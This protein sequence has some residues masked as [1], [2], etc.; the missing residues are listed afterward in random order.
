M[1]TGEH[2]CQKGMVINMDLTVIIP[3]YNVQ[4]YIAAC[5]RSVMHFPAKTEN[6]Q[7]IEIECLVIND[8]SSDKTAEI[9]TRY[10]QRDKRIRLISQD[11]AG[12]SAARNRGLQEAC[13][14]YIMFLDADDQLCEDAFECIT[15]AIRDEYAEF[16][17]F[18]YIT[19]YE[20]GKCVSQELPIQGNVSLDRKEGNRLMYADSVFNTCW[21]KMFLNEIIRQKN[22]TFRVDLP[23]GED[24][25]FVLEYYS[26][27][28]TVYMT[29]YPILYYLQRSGSAMR[30][31]SMEKRLEFTQLL[32]T[33]H[34]EAVDSYHDEMLSEQMAVYYVKVLTN[35]FLE[36]VAIESG[37]ALYQDY[38]KA[39]QTAI[40]QEILSN[41]RETDISSRMKKFEYRLLSQGKVKSLLRYFSIKKKFRR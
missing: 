12:V 32:Y 7:A 2:S 17:A 31:Y 16:M 4:D 11:N 40:V 19:L 26:S 1:A 5:L 9:V 33:F 24:F 21:G 10:A 3:A 34:K 22:I 35:L 36:Y 29:K 30:S 13:G 39:L 25:L 8:G 23:V 27:C 14:R 15:E 6:Q 41:V 20:N 18:S 28:K 38:D 37:Q